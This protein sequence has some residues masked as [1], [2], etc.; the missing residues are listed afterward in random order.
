MRKFITNE[1]IE[2]RAAEIISAYEQK[3]GTVVRPPVPVEKIFMKVYDLHVEWDEIDEDEGITILGGLKP[4]ERMIVLNEKHRE[5]FTAKPGLERSTIGHE[6]GH[7]E[8]DV[9]NKALGQSSLFR[10]EVANAFVTR[11]GKKFGAISVFR[12]RIEKVGVSRDFH[13]SIARFDTPDQTRIVNRFAAAL[14][15]PKH[16]LRHAVKEVD[17]QSWKGLYKLADVFEVTITALKVR[18]EQ[19]GYTYFDGKDFHRNKQEAFGQGSLF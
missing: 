16:L 19:L 17:L 10:P 11:S 12:G 3:T 6:G 1:S 5:L 14:N 9:E 15:M 4:E 7:W 2:L 13:A 18:L 8:Y